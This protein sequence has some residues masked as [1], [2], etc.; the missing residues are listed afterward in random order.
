MRTAI[1]VLTLALAM[2]MAPLGAGENDPKYP[3]VNTAITYT[4][5]AS[6]PARPGDFRWGDMPGIAVDAADNVYIFTRSEPP[7][8]V[9]R[10]DG[11]LVRSWGR[12]TFKTPHHIRIDRTGNV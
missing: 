3:H 6:W 9:Y 5:D 7:V 8:Q 2:P 1:P 12:N 11:K 4:V 10:A